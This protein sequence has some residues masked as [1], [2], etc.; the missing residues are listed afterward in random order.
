M[1]PGKFA[2]PTFLF[3]SFAVE[4]KDLNFTGILDIYLLLDIYLIFDIY[5]MFDIYLLS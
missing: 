3:L 2:L 4:A 1:I 5:P